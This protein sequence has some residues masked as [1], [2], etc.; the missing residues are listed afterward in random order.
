[1]VDARSQPTRI[2]RLLAAPADPHYVV[3]LLRTETVGGLLLLTAALVAVAWASSPWGGSYEALRGVTFG[4]EPLH[5]RLDLATWAADGLLAVFFF[6]VGMELKREFVVGD[7]RDP[8]RA[9]LP[10]MAAVGGMAVPALIYTAVNLVGDGPLSGWAVPTATDIAFALGVLAVVGS[11]LPLA[12]RSF[13]LTLAVVDDL[14]A[15][16]VIAVFYTSD[17]AWLP[18][19]LALVPIALF[20]VVVGRRRTTWWLLWPLG[21]AAWALVHASGVH[22]TVAGVVLGLLVP[23]LRPGQRGRRLTE[24]LEHRFRPLSAGFCVPVFALM[25]AGV[26][27]NGETARA[28]AADPVAIGIAVGLVAG[29]VLGVLGTTWLVARFTRAELDPGL[30]WVDLFGMSL[31]A[32]IGFTVSLLIGELAFGPGSEVD[33][34]VR[35]AVLTASVTAAVL[36]SVVL[37]SRNRAYRQAAEAAG[38]HDLDGIPDHE[39]VDASDRVVNGPDPAPSAAREH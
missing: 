12:L 33:D 21:I 9:A 34:H 8:R 16:T 10:M 14:L 17:L 38:D 25:A 26:A 28:A 13:L 6:V 35:I 20:R 22:A 1:M 2:R 3:Q 5:L 36:A 18:L 30:R 37:A 7:L 29:K 31:L 19:V 11:H 32:G 27:V 15:I 39:Q 24:D 23:V 4:P